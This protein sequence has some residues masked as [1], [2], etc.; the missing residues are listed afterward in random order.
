MHPRQA[1]TAPVPQ[2]TAARTTGTPAP[3]RLVNR[4]PALRLSAVATLPGGGTIGQSFGPQY[5]LQAKVLM[6]ASGWIGVL[7]QLPPELHD[8]FS[9]IMSNGLEIIVQAFMRL[10]EQHVMIRG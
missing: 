10:D 3:S 8:G 5:L 9:F 2:S 7:R 4:R 6:D 1:G